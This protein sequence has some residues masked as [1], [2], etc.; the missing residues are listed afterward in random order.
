MIDLLPL[1]PDSDHLCPTDWP[2]RSPC[3]SDWGRSPDWGRLDT[4]I[5]W[6][7]IPPC[8][9]GDGS[10]SDWGRYLWRRGRQ[11]SGCLRSRRVKRTCPLDS[12][13]GEFH[14][15]S[16]ECLNFKFRCLAKLYGVETVIFVLVRRLILT[17]VES[18]IR[19]TV[20]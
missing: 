15:E 16:I 18:S 7:D 11:G 17:T 3:L 13:E 9:T 19:L 6:Q 4:R 12:K 5:G 10:V 8:Q 1:S 14:R 20:Q 2:R